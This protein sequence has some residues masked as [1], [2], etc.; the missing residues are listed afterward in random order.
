MFNHKANNFEFD[1]EVSCVLSMQSI[2]T[3]TLVRSNKQ[4]LSPDAI[5]VGKFGSLLLT[6]LTLPR[7]A[8]FEPTLQVQPYPYSI[9]IA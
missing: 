6:G 5:K 8:I 4:T 9:D 7:R 1:F 2:I 3:N